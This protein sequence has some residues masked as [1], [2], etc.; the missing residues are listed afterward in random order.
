MVTGV[1]RP[2]FSFEGQDVGG[3]DGEPLGF[4][5]AGATGQLGSD[6]AKGVEECVVAIDDRV[7][8]VV[9]GLDDLAVGDRLVNRR[10]EGEVVA[11]D[12]GASAP[13]EQQPAPLAAGE[14]ERLDPA[15]GKVLH[16]TGIGDKD[17]FGRLGNA[18][19]QTLA[20][21]E[22]SFAGQHG[23][24]LSVTVGRTLC[25]GERVVCGRPG[26]CPA[27][28]TGLRAGKVCGPA[29]SAGCGGDDSGALP[30]SQWGRFRHWRPLIRGRNG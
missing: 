25:R 19:P 1:E 7:L 29:K 13:F 22:T 21:G 15:V 5:Q 18:F 26:C 3:G 11:H 9:P 6:L 8:V 16:V 20:S 14:A 27:G 10:T 4:D 2:G 24:V 12:R 23:V 28:R 17:P 30:A